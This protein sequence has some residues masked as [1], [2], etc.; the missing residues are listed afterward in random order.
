MWVSP[1][2]L[3]G[4]SAPALALP[5]PPLPQHSPVHTPLPTR[6]LRLCGPNPSRGFSPSSKMVCPFKSEN[7]ENQTNH[8]GHKGRVD[9]RISGTFIH[10]RYFWSGEL[11]S[12]IFPLLN[13]N[14]YLHPDSKW[15]CPRHVPGPRWLESLL[16]AGFL[17]W[18]APGSDLLARQRSFCSRVVNSA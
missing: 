4:Q 14:S 17:C 13:D 15:P 1:A 18:A 3:R 8:R 5:G 6:G 11:A 12:E 10:G 9:S 2:L 16:H 7:V